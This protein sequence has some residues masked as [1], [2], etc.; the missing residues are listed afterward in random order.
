MNSTQ[1]IEEIAKVDLLLDANMVDLFKRVRCIPDSCA[2]FETAHRLCPDLTVR[3][4]V[5]MRQRGNLQLVRDEAINREWQAQQRREAA[6]RRKAH[7][8]ARI[9][10]RPCTACTG[11]GYQIAA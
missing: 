1:A 8:A 3:R 10:F 11:T 4:D 9:Q 5:L 7:K 2:A 6:A